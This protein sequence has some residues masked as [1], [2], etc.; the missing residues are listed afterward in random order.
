VSLRKSERRLRR[1]WKPH[2]LRKR[3]TTQAASTSCINLG[4]RDTLETTLV[5]EKKNYAG[6]RALPASIKE[7]HWP[8]VP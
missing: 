1:Q 6:S 7:I 3:K 5:E 4:K 8:E 2:R